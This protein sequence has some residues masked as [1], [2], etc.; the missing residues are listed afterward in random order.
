MAQEPEIARFAVA[1]DLMHDAVVVG[2][3]QDVGAALDLL[4]L[5]GIREIVVVDDERRIVGL[6][7]EAEI[8]Q[9]YRTATSE[10]VRPPAAQ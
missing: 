5:H 9:L 1:D 7:D 10:S 8:A 6:L 3:G 4:F 2:E